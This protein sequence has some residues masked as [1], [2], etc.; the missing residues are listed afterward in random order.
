MLTKL[1]AYFVCESYLAG[2]ARKIGIN[3]VVLLGLGEVKNQG[4][5]K[6]SIL[7]DTFEAVV[8]AI[9]LSNGIEIA[10]D[11]VKRTVLENIDN[12]KILVE[13]NKTGDYKAVL[14]NLAT[15]K[16]YGEPVYTYEETGPDH[17]KMYIVTLTFPNLPVFQATG[18]ETTR[19]KAA[20]LAAKNALE[21]FAAAK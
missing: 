10:T 6:D 2:V 3:N 5:E 9:Y 19:R 15:Q 13:Q 8:A 12:A 18:E 4:N 21:Q 16:N 20:S 14:R 17:A 11:F 1:R 7:S